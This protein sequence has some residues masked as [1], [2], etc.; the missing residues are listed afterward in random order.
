MLRV[1]PGA[2][3]TAIGW[4]FGVVDCGTEVP[5]LET[6]PA[7]GALAPDGLA[8]LGLL[9]A[10]ACEEAAVLPLLLPPPQPASAAQTRSMA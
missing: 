2:V 7:D 9:A 6:S 3:L 1:R 8:A 10:P 4:T 5:V